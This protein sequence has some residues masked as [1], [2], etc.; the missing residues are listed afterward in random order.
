MNLW[1]AAQKYNK[2]VMIYHVLRYAPINLRIKEILN[3][4][5]IGDIKS[6]QTEENFWSYDFINWQEKIIFDL[7]RWK[8]YN[9][10]ICKAEDKIIWR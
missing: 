7:L 5:T 9:T 2:K 4:G 1:D 10:S 3:K 8:L 6:I